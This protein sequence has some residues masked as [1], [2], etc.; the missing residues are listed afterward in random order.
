MSSFTEF[1]SSENLSIDKVYIDKFYHSICN[2]KWVL[3][4]ENTLNWCGYESL[5]KEYKIKQRYLELISSKFIKEEEYKILTLSQFNSYDKNQLN[6]MF[7]IKKN[8]NNRNTY[9]IVNPRTFKESLMLMDT[10]KSNQIRKYYLDLEEYFNKYVEYTSG[11]EIAKLKEENDLLKKNQNTIKV[12]YVPEYKPLLMESYIYVMTTK[13]YISQNLFKIG[14]TTNLEKRVKQHKTGRANGDEMYLVFSMKVYNSDNVEK[15]IFNKLESFKHNKYELFN[16]NYHMLMDLMNEFKRCEEENNKN[17][18][19]IFSKYNPEEIKYVYM[20]NNIEEIEREA[21]KSAEIDRHK[22]YT[23]PVV[24]KIK[25][26]NEAKHLSTEIIN[27]KFKNV[28]LFLQKEYTGNCEEKQ[29]WSCMN[30]LNHTFEC[31]YSHAKR[32]YLDNNKGCP[33]CRKQQVL[34]KVKW[35]SYDAKTLEF[36]DE[37]DSWEDLKE[38]EKNVLDTDDK[39]K[40]I[41]NIVREQRWLTPVEDIVYSILSPDEK[42]KLNLNKVLTPYETF[43]IQILEIN[44]NMM[45]Q[46]IFKTKFNFIISIDEKNGKAYVSDS[47]TQLS[48][49]LTYVGTIDKK[50]NR[51][52]IAKYVDCE[53]VYAGYIFRS[54]DNG[55]I[56]EYKEKYEVSML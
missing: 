33:Y 7:G 45:K 12:Y 15:F 34:D 31:A 41:K 23:P 48:L 21:Y 17:I 51:K 47:M 8:T 5:N 53:K 56:E 18:N 30:I 52:T 13:S 35:Y 43:I 22:K 10:K 37:F 20:S 49:K 24:D 46:R 44:Y 27:E 38:K 26:I 28:N 36:I 54:C 29:V 2:K 1:I 39:V 11:L 50:L 42:N 25:K 32:E 3:V 9:I 4:C 14:Q 19:S 40:I 55:M 16:I 6:C